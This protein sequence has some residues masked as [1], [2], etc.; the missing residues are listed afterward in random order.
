M[1]AVLYVCCTSF[2]LLIVLLQLKISAPTAALMMMNPK[3]LFK[4]ENPFMMEILTINLF[5]LGLFLASE[6][7]L[8]R[9]EQIDEAAT[10]RIFASG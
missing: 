2:H 10:N 9:A 1:H 3:I 6:H 4:G 8:R 5:F 7:R